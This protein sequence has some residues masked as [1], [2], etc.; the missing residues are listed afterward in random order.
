MQFGETLCFAIIFDCDPC[1]VRGIHLDFTQLF[2]GEGI[3]I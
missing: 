2:L 3:T 1:S